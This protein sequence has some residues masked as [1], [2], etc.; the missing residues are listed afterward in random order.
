MELGAMRLNKLVEIL[1]GV[2]LW[3]GQADLLDRG[4]DIARR[5]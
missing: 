5:P 2:L 3:F 4:A 1:I